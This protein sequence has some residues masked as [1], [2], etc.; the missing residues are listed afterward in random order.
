MGAQKYHIGKNG[1]APCNAHP[2]LPNGRACRFGEELHGTESEM[3]KLWDSEQEAANPSYLEGTS[4]GKLDSL[5]LEAR[6]QA[7]RSLSDKSQYT[8]HRD[9]EL[10][11]VAYSPQEQEIA[12]KL[13]LS[14]MSEFSYAPAERDMG[15]ATDGATTVERYVTA[16]G[17]AGYFKAF[18]R[19]SFMEEDF[20]RWGGVSSLGGSTNEVNAY[21]LA[22]AMGD[23]YQSLVPETVFREAGGD[24]GTIQ[25][26]V[27]EEPEAEKPLRQIESAKIELRRDMKRAA[28]YDFVLGNFDR[29]TGNFL[30]GVEETPDGSKQLR[31]KL[32]DNTF[33]FPQ[34]GRSIR[35]SYNQST[36][37]DDDRGWVAKEGYELSGSDR[38]AL[39]RAQEAISGW[40]KDGTIDPSRAWPALERIDLLLES[41]RI[42]N[43]REHLNEDERK[44][45]DQ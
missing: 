21:R 8:S 30:Y 39:N 24:I 38:K 32:I 4:N 11:R 28:I 6:S 13:A 14:T 31:L 35:D 1:P 10:V 37:A 23:E 27:A 42:R 25:R 9:E 29:H 33:S 36:F 26:E 12:M 19:N 45:Q 5:D 20:E 43:L 34:E 16:D 17:S 2:E 44:M 7:E 40:I 41:G 22:L 15:W 18:R 3:A